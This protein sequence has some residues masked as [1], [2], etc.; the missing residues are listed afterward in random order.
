MNIVSSGWPAACE[1]CVLSYM[2][3]R[4]RTAVLLHVASFLSVALWFKMHGLYAVILKHR[5]HTGA[6]FLSVT[7]LAGGGLFRECVQASNII[8]TTPAVR[9]IANYHHFA[10]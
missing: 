10:L 1:A 2:S 8:V 6:R 9:A 5:C 7:E 4:Q 3:Y